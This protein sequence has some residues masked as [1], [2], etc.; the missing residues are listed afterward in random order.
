MTKIATATIGATG[1]VLMHGPVIQSGY[2]RTTNSYDFGYIYEYF[3]TC[4]S[5]VDYAVANLEVTLCGSDN[6]YRYQGY[7]TFNCPD[8]ITT[9]LKNAGFDMVLTANNHSY[10][11]GS[12]GF[13]RT[14]Q[15]VEEAGLAHIGTRPTLEDDPYAVVDVNGI[16]I[17]MIN[18]TY[19][20]GVKD[21]GAVSL[22]GIALSVEN[23]QLVNTFSYDR[24]DTFYSTISGQIEAMRAEGAEAVVLYI[25]WGDEYQ[26]KQNAKQ[27][28]MSQKLCDMG[29]DVIVGNHP[30]VIQPMQLLTSTAD[31]EHKTLCLYS[32]GNSVSNQTNPVNTQ[33]GVFLEFTFAKYSDGTVLVES[34]HVIPT[35]VNRYTENGL[36]KYQILYMDDT[37]E[38]WAATLGISEA[39]IEK[40]QKS[41]DRT[42]NTIGEGLDQANEYYATNQQTVEADLGVE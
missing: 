3:N 36:T 40:C 2:D 8:A 22:N 34:T 35:F 14:Q 30:H 25:H 10:D 41:Y 9:A 38:D 27:D 18:Y 33:D 21:S 28:A 32:T 24:L 1:D 20:T 23:S 13:G 39:L 26:S 7:P 15:I 12:K 11:T 29:I 42:M 17:G 5:R 6:G 37:L 4:V 31:P 19:N 16:K